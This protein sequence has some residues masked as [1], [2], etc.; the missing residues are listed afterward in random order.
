MIPEHLY[1]SVSS[2]LLKETLDIIVC[3]G[4]SG[5]TTSPIPGSKAD[6]GAREIATKVLNP[7]VRQCVVIC[8]EEINRLREEFVAILGPDQFQHVDKAVKR[9]L[10]RIAARLKGDTAETIDLLPRILAPDG[11]RQKDPPSISAG[12]SS[13]APKSVN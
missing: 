13:E 6:G 11:K 9:S 10:R 5:V 1:Q 8:V 4:S 2:A 12:L 7:I 3:F